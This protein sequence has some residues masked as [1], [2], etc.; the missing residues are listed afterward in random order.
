M[1]RSH[2]QAFRTHIEASDDGDA[3]KRRSLVE[4]MIELGDARDLYEQDRSSL[5]ADIEAFSPE[6]RQ[7]TSWR[8]MISSTRRAR[9]S[10]PSPRRSRG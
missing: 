7:P 9:R 1:L 10:I 4:A 6:C 2:L 8:R 3:E 5:V